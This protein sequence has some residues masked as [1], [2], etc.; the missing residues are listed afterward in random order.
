M[1]QTRTKYGILTGVD[2]SPA[3]EAAI[4]WAAREAVNRHERLTLAHV[5]QPVSLDWPPPL[6]GTPNEISRW[7][8]DHAQEVLEQARRSVVA[9]TGAS[10][11]VDVQTVALRSNVVAALA[12]AS[13]EASMIVV[14]SRGGGALGR[15][16]TRARSAPGC[17]TMRTVRWWSR[18]PVTVRRPAPMHP[19]YSGSTVRRSPRPPP[20]GHSTRRHGVTRHCWSCTRGVMSERSRVLDRAW[21]TC[22]SQGDEVLAE[23]LAGWQERFPDVH[24]TRRL[25]RDTPARWLLEEAERAQ[26]VVVGSRG[27]G[28]SL[29]TAARLGQLRSCA[30]GSSAGRGGSPTVRATGLRTRPTPAAAAVAM[31]DNRVPVLIVGAGAAGLTSV[32]CWPNTECVQCWSRSVVRPSSTRK[33]AT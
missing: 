16:L 8:D 17:C 31:N 11:A 13:R 19:W 6:H 21:D 27:R 4:A 23:R 1:P 30:V 32:P 20:R 9:A 14:G 5:A 10:Q 28:G 25:V 22:E 26:L 12:D 33:P 2:G 29:G 24:V 7:Q 15:L 18:M 3:A